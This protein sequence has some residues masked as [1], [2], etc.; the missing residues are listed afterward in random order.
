[1]HLTA[2]RDVRSQRSSRRAFEHPASKARHELVTRA[3]WTSD[4]RVST[5][6]D[7][8]SRSWSQPSAATGSAIS[9]VDSRCSD[10]SRAG[11]APED[12]WL[13]EPA[14]PPAG[15]GTVGKVH[16]S[17]AANISVC[18]RNRGEVVSPVW[19]ETSSAK[20]RGPRSVNFQD[21][22]EA[23]PTS[24]RV[25][26]GG[27]ETAALDPPGARRVG[28]EGRR[29]RAKVDEVR[30]AFPGPVAAVNREAELPPYIVAQAPERSGETWG[31]CPEK[32][33]SR[34]G[35]ALVASWSCTGSFDDHA[36]AV[37]LRVSSPGASVTSSR[38]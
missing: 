28:L 21:H 9:G 24:D 32:A 27:K 7:I 12:A 1:M 17:R 11:E 18:S 30:D 36:H 16:Q 20:A 10:L 15:C 8:D 2:P 31:K 19:P 22:D 23:G 38:A 3:R 34:S 26:L 4:S 33:R 6:I 14:E 25:A 35:H 5:S 13:E 29:L 37:A